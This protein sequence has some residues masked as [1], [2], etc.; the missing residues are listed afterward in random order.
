MLRTPPF[1]G[2]N[3]S[4]WAKQQACWKTALETPVPVARGFVEFTVSPEDSNAA[5]RDQ[6]ATG[7]VDRGLEAVKTV[8]SRDARYWEALRR[9]GRARRLFSSGDENT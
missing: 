1:A 8:M 6:R 7:S 2:R 9:F 3:I 4:E 5:R